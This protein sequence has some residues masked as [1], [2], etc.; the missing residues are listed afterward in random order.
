MLSGRVAKPPSEWRVV[1][2]GG[3]VREAL[4]VLWEASD[5][6]SSKRLKA[7]LLPALERHRRLD[8]DVELR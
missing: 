5:R 6:L 2:Y 8:L 1:C 7:V 3:A 4:V